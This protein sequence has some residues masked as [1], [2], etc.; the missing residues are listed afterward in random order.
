MLYTQNRR[1]C[2]HFV[3]ALVT[4][5]SGKR[6]AYFIKYAADAKKH[7]LAD[8]IRTIAAESAPRTADEFRLLTELNIDLIT[9]KNSRRIVECGCRLDLEA[10]GMVRNH[11][12]SSPRVVTP[13][14]VARDTGLGRRG[15]NALIAL[16]QSGSVRLVDA[17][18]TITL[19]T[20][21]N[22]SVGRCFS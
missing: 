11:L 2:E 22:N 7:G 8:L 3:D 17:T 9:I 10:T 18:S 21:F 19:D 5:S 20:Q 6:V 16:L 15:S 4:F 1:T 12:R 13:R 14:S